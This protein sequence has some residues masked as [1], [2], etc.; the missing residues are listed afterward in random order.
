MDVSNP[1]ISL[2][3]RYA[4]RQLSDKSIVDEVLSDLFVLLTFV[5]ICVVALLER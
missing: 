4:L 5:P 2:R 3:I 1:I